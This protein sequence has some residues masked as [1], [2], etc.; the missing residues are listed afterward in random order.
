MLVC[1]IA[2]IL[3]RV[4][5][6]A[7]DLNNLGNMRGILIGYS[8][9]PKVKGTASCAPTASDVV[10]SIAVQGPPTETFQV[11]LELLPFLPVR[12]FLG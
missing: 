10:R 1:H 2:N 4:S 8:D 6:K 5:L 11:G 12:F 3:E 7:G 9:D